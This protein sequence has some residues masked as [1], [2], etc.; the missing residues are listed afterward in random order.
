MTLEDQ[1]AF[2]QRGRVCWLGVRPARRA[3]VQVVDAVE[4][5]VG[6]GLVGDHYRARKGDREVTL[7]QAEHLALLAALLGRD[8]A[9]DPAL[10]RRN[11]LVAGINLLGLKRRTFQIGTAI[12]EYTGLAD[13]CSRMEEALGPGGWNAMCGHGGITA[14]VL[15]GGVIRLQDAVV[16]LGNSDPLP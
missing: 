2:P 10:L 13:P 12:L 8:A 5:R 4:A 15:R 7:I 14:R 3:A 11:I 6:E 1:F 16:Y 9:V